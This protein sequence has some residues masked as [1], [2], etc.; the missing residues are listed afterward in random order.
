MGV[1]S[2]DRPSI[3]ALRVG[4]AT[5]AAPGGPVGHKTSRGLLALC[6]SSFHLLSFL[7][8]DPQQPWTDGGEAGHPLRELHL[9]DEDVLRPGQGAMG[10]WKDREQG[11][12]PRTELL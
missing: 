8:T 5:S 2:G 3:S 11:A 6:L 1:C 7:A 9:Q 4:T 10:V 12:D